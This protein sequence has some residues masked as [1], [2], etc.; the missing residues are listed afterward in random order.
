MRPNQHM[1]R[2]R[3][4]AAAKLGVGDPD[5]VL[6][7]FGGNAVIDSQTPDS[8]GLGDGGAIDVTTLM[9]H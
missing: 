2:V 3:A 1:S 6:L 8:I 9:P 5:F 4:V 7:M